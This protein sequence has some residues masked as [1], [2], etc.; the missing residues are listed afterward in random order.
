M[1][2]VAPKTANVNEWVAPGSMNLIGNPKCNETHKNKPTNIV[3]ALGI[4]NPSAPTYGT[5]NFN[6]HLSRTIMDGKPSNFHPHPSNFQYKPHSS[7][8][9]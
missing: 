5:S 9:S 1:V 7:Y 6:Q 8:N 3:L 4:V 2:L